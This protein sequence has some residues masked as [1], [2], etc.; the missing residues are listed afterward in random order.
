[1][2]GETCAT[3]EASANAPAAVFTMT[4]E[5]VVL[6]QRYLTA[7]QSLDQI[8][9]RRQAFCRIFEP[10]LKPRECLCEGAV[11]K[12]PTHGRKFVPTA[13]RR[14]SDEERF[15]SAFQSAQPNEGTYMARRGVSDA[16]DGAFGGNS[17]IHDAQNLA[18]KLA[19]VIRREAG[20]A[21]PDSYDTA[22]WRCRCLRTHCSVIRES[23][24]GHSAIA[25]SFR[26]F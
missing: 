7:S 5:G 11:N 6:G 8:D 10:F 26:T 23:V 21:L 12:G 15:L 1:M 20:S 3:S 14:T 22:A 4:A 18:W 2:D 9:L 16:S 19:M 13:A 25:T 24:L 17:G